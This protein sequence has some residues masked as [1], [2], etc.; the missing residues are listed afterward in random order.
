VR[1]DRRM[2]EGRGKMDERQRKMDG[3]RKEDKQD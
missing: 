3:G 2:D 1:K